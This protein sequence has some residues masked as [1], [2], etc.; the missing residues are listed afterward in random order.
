MTAVLGKAL[1]AWAALA[2]LAVGNGALREGVLIP[3]FGP[4]AGRAAS[5]AILLALGWGATALM[6]R[7]TGRLPVATAWGIGALWLILIVGVET[8]VGRVEGRGWGEIA[9]N[10]HP[11]APT[12]WPWV[13]L[14]IV[15]APAAL[16]ALSPPAP[17]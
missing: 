8:G 5:A 2:A 12:L 17:S 11:L 10:Y 1:V 14:G 3:R 4:T 13:L 16:T 6:L 9:A 7:W 15:V